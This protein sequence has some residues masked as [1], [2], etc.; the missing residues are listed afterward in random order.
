[1]S[2]TRSSLSC[3]FTAKTKTSVLERVLWKQR[4]YLESLPIKKLFTSL[5]FLLECKAFQIF[6]F[7]DFRCFKTA[8]VTIYCTS[9]FYQ[10][11]VYNAFLFFSARPPV[12]L[13]KMKRHSGNLVSNIYLLLI[14]WHFFTFLNSLL[15]F[16]L[17]SDNWIFLANWGGAGWKRNRK[18]MVL[19]YHENE[20]WG[21]DG[22]GRA[23][24]YTLC[25]AW[26]N[27]M[28]LKAR[29]L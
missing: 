9:N 18:R 28:D 12:G 19:L 8:T 21:A 15:L 6:I 17:R 20:K 1:M 26:R 16:A 4:S 10:D 2:P 22:R 11:L 14:L 24:L 7:K 3:N 5:T 23:R 25:S 13:L 27:A 29:R